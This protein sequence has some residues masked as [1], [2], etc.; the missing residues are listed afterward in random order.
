[1]GLVYMENYKES[2]TIIYYRL[3]YRLT[4]DYGNYHQYLLC[5]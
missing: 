4:G 5:A 2:H 1:M 3:G